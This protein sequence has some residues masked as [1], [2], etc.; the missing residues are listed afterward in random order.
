M[1]R[2]QIHPP[3]TPREPLLPEAPPPPTSPLI[4]LGVCWTQPYLTATLRHSCHAVY[5]MS[6]FLSGCQPL[7]KCLCSWHICVDWLLLLCLTHQIPSELCDS[8][9]CGL[10]RTTETHSFS[11]C[12][13]TFLS[14]SNEQ[15][16]DTSTIG[17]IHIPRQAKYSEDRSAI[18]FLKGIFLRDHWN[19]MSPS[20]EPQH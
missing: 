19:K 8:R 1:L 13:Y 7:I 16:M 5:L 14:T 18:L 20:G 11:I 4:W 3:D 6:Q 2:V 10:Y 9:G 17:S 12:V 15:R